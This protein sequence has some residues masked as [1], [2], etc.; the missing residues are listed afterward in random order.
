M[1]NQGQGDQ[2][3]LVKVTKA[4]KA[5]VLHEEG[6]PLGEPATT[7]NEEPEEP[8]EPCFFFFYGT[9]MDPEVLRTV[10]AL[11]SLPE[12]QDAWLAGFEMKMWNGRYPTLLPKEGMSPADTIQGK[13]WQATSI[14]QCLRLQLY[15]TSAYECCDCVVQTGEGQSITALTFKWARDPGSA[16]LSSSKGGF[17]LEHW[18]KNY[19]PLMF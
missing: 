5:P 13:S 14:D 18:Q 2:T 19:K 10:A 7:E 1:A 17:D 12:L 11:D 4:G 15:E 3:E 16:Q 9:L 8:F 6:Q